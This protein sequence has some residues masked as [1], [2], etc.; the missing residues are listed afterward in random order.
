MVTSAVA[1]FIMKVITSDRLQIRRCTADE[2]ESIC[3]LEKESYPADEAASPEKLK[4][5]LNTASSFFL[6]AFQDSEL[7]GYVTGTLSNSDVVTEE[8]MSHHEPAGSTL[9]I[10]SVVVKPTFQRQGVATKLLQHYLQMLKESGVPKAALLCKP[11]LCPLYE[12]VGFKNQGQSATCHGKSP[13]IDMT[14][15]FT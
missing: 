9:C 7:I 4:Y 12:K 2:F 5:R 13:W 1:L 8:S 15:S 11:K 3:K 6:G 14:L 10:H